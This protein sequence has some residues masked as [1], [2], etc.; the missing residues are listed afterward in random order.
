MRLA[1]YIAALV[2]V[3]SAAIVVTLLIDNPVGAVIPVIAA[4]IGLALLIRWHARNTT[5]I[6]EKCGYQFDIGPL[7]DFI[8]PHLPE[9]K[10]LSC[11][12]CGKRSWCH[13]STAN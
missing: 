10:L 12:S 7:I 13:A 11:P 2:I 6:C 9:R 3:M 1:V 8:S 5:Y 4:A